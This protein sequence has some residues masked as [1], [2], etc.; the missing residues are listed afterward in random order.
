MSKHTSTPGTPDTHKHDADTCAQ[1]GTSRRDFLKSSAVGLAAG[2]IAGSGLGG[3]ALATPPNPPGEPPITGSGHRIL[4]K[5]GIVLTLDSDP[6]NPD[7]EK[8]DV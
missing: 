2:A 4:L 8:G 3:S 1:G 6:S 7:L 5:G